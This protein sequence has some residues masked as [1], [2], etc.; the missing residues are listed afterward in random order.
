MKLETKTLEVLEELKEDC[1]EKLKE[2]EY[3]ITITDSQIYCMY[4]RMWIKHYE[5]KLAQIEAEIKNR[6]EKH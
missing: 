2:H 4:Q 5:N 1:I 6:K 3:Y